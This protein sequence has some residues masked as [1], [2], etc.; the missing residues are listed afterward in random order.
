M[1]FPLR[2]L[3]HDDRFFDLLNASAENTLEGLRLRT[4]CS[5]TSSTSSA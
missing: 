3:P 5:T 1:L 2:L 4:T